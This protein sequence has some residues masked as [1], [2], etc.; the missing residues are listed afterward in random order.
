MDDVLATLARETTSCAP[1]RRIAP[2]LASLLTEMAM[3]LTNEL[4]IAGVEDGGTA[5]ASRNGGIHVAF[6]AI[7]PLDRRWTSPSSGR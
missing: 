2:R 4:R 1:T 7:A 3:R 6:D 5:D